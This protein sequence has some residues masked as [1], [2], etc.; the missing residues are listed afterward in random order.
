MKTLIESLALVFPNLRTIH[1]HN[2][3][4]AKACPCFDV[5]KEHSRQN[6]ELAEIKKE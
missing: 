2:E 4:A 3:F 6:E 1:G 5:S